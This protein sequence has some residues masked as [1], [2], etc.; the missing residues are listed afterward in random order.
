MTKYQ[1][2]QEYAT[3]CEAA[4]VLIADIASDP[5][6]RACGTNK[7]DG[8][9]TRCRAAIDSLAAAQDAQDTVMFDAGL[10]AIPSCATCGSYCH[11][12]TQ[13]AAI[14]AYDQSDA[15]A[16]IRAEWDSYLG[17]LLPSYSTSRARIS[18]GIITV[19]PVADA[20]ADN[21]FTFDPF[22]CD[23]STLP[24]IAD[25]QSLVA[26]CLDYVPTPVITAPY[27][28]SLTS[29]PVILPTARA[30][31]STPRAV[32]DTVADAALTGIT[33]IEARRARII[34]AIKTASTAHDL[35]CK[36]AAQQSIVSLCR[37]YLSCPV[38]GQD[39]TEI[40]KSLDR[41][42]WASVLTSRAMDIAGILG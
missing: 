11:T 7:V 29:D 1:V 19:L 40:R 9:C 13:C 35:G 2:A 42:V 28:G 15:D 20:D 21:S 14:A 16:R 38:D 32:K 31:N 10:A 26:P 27:A 36:Y 34:A 30:A 33:E 5:V 17:K 12:S 24:C 8:V 41:A 22:T 39:P 4:S 3:E 6:C 25:L 18:N 23:T 37:A